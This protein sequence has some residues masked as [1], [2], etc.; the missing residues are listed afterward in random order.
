VVGGLLND[1]AKGCF[2]TQVL[3]DGD[4]WDGRGWAGLF[5]DPYGVHVGGWEHIAEAG[6]MLEGVGRW[7]DLNWTTVE[8][9]VFGPKCFRTQ[10]FWNGVLY[11][12]WLR[13]VVVPTHPTFACPLSNPRTSFV[14]P[15]CPT[16]ANHAPSNPGLTY[17]RAL[18]STSV[19]KHFPV[20]KKLLRPTFAWLLSNPCT[21]PVQP[22]YMRFLLRAAWVL[23]PKG[24]LSFTA[25][26][27]KFGPKCFS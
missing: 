12:W 2:R 24:P 10:V 19:Q 26:I 21:A 8:Q 7:L 11:G 23:Y 4:L 17:L 27:E 5:G 16:R 9:N 18:G 15:L 3:G 25:R 14:H 6:G 20:Q 1:R 22:P 13:G